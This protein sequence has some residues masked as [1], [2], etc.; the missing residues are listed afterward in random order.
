MKRAVKGRGSHYSVPCATPCQIDM[1]ACVRTT[2]KANSKQ[3]EKEGQGDSGV[4]TP[5]WA[6]SAVCHSKVRAAM[7]CELSI[8][9][10]IQWKTSPLLPSLIRP[11]QPGHP[12]VDCRTISLWSRV[13]PTFLFSLSSSREL[14][15]SLEEKFC[16]AAFLHLASPLSVCMCAHFCVIF[17]VHVI[18]Y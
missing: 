3:L 14:F 9:Y 17:L 1:A 15:S 7:F 16:S 12:R 8:L 4:E 13:T 2:S 6:T 11:P 5:Y 18:Q 10:H